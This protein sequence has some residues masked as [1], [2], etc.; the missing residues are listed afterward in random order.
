MKAATLPFLIAGLGAGVWSNDVAATAD[1]CQGP[2]L[3]LRSLDRTGVRQAAPASPTQAGIDALGGTDAGEISLQGLLTHDRAC[4]VADFSALSRAKHLGDVDDLPTECLAAFARTARIPALHAIGVTCGDG[5]AIDLQQLLAYPALETVRLV[6]GCRTGAGGL[7]PLAGLPRLR[8]LI[9]DDGGSLAGLETLTMLTSLVIRPAD[10]AI[11]PLAKLPGL[12]ALEITLYQPV[13]LTTIGGLSALEELVIGAQAG[14]PVDV[15]PLVKLAG[16][17]RLEIAADGI[18]HGAA[19]A[20]LGN[21]CALELSRAGRGIDLAALAGLSRLRTLRIDVSGA[22]SLA[23]LSRLRA[24]ETI[25]LASGCKHPV[26]DLAP[27]AKLPRLTS[28]ALEGAMKAAN[29]AALGER[30]H[31]FR[32]H[33]CRGRSR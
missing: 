10:A 15:T 30:V 22:P 28:V 14:A 5:T 1:I 33:H 17:R 23:P 9:D 29:Q 6:F 19:L 16:L 20:G 25:E 12:R 4:P 8:T 11:V 18:A 7:A 27:L 24:L 21:L 31:Q 3:Y 2:G 13:D 32:P 26:I